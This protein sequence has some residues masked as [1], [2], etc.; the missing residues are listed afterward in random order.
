MIYA[1]QRCASAV[2]AEATLKIAHQ[3]CQ[4]GPEM[5]ADLATVAAVGMGAV[6]AETS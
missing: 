1:V 2:G 3:K 5:R 4:S 6:E